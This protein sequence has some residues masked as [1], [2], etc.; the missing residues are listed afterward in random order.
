MEK[1]RKITTDL[2]CN[3]D[4]VIDIFD[5]FAL[6]RSEADLG[7]T[8][9]DSGKGGESE[10]ACNSSKHSPSLLTEFKRLFNIPFHA[11]DLTTSPFLKTYTPVSRRELV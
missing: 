7:Y 10:I 9:Q 4:V 11:S 8:L 5:D 1:E 3:H 2:T 6:E